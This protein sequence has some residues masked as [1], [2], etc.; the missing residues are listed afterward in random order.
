MQLFGSRGSQRVRFFARSCG[1]GG[2]LWVEVENI[3]NGAEDPDD[4]EVVAHM[5]DIS[6][7]MAAHEALRRREQLFEPAGRGAC[8]PELCRLSRDG[9][10]IY[11]NAR[12]REILHAATP[13]DLQ[14]LL[15]A[16][17]GDDRSAVRAAVD[18]ALGPGHRLP[19]G[20]QGS[21]AR[22]PT[23]PP[24]CAMTVAAVAD[25]EGHPAVLYV[26][27]ATS[28]RA[29]GCAKSCASKRCTTC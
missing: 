18:A 24:F 16:I 1:D 22:R 6:D 5:S 25:Q 14:T 4:A 28:R 13:S 2:W 17:L 21:P 9:S 3:H 20:G 10:V 7:E 15:S 29:P 19:V 12:L 8:L 11:A 27:G 23:R 26:V